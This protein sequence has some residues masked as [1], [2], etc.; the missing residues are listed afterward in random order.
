MEAKAKG[1]E[2][3]VSVK[4]RGQRAK[5]MKLGD[6][7]MIKTGQA[8]M[9]YTDVDVCHVLMRQG[10]IG[11]KVSIM[12]PQDPRGIMGPKIPLDDVVTILE[13]KDELS[14]AEM[15][16]AQQQ[17][18]AQSVPAAAYPEAAADPMDMAPAVDTLAAPQA[19]V[20]VPGM[21]EGML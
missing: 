5:A 21:D 2:V 13:P 4:L 8:G 17:Q 18:Q 7:Y 12:L 6:V 19:V 3:V 14:P 9:I 1:C 10:V 15:L 16:A 20:E 11:I